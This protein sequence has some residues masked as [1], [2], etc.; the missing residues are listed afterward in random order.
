MSN[1]PQEVTI[2]EVQIIGR[3]KAARITIPSERH[4]RSA[5]FRYEAARFLNVRVEEIFHMEIIERC[6]PN[7]TNALDTGLLLDCMVVAN[8][9]SWFIACA[10]QAK[11]AENS[12]SESLARLQTASD[13]L[14]DAVRDYEARYT[15]PITI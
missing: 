10:E 14:R 7:H 11:T 1:R 15:E 3:D 6:D 12:S 4:W 2:L 8:A 9:A 13:A 5:K